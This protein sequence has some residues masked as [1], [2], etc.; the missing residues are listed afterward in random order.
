M[1]MMAKVREGGVHKKLGLGCK[2]SDCGLKTCTTHH[3]IVTDF[4]LKAQNRQRRQQD[5]QSHAGHTQVQGEM[6]R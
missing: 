1:H 2:H 6:G 5:Q 3:D 4:N